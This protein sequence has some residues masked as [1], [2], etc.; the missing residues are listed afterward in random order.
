MSNGHGEDLSGAHLG[1]ALVRLG[2]HAV[3]F[4]LVGH[5]EAYKQLGIPTQPVTTHSF[6]THGMGYQSLGGVLQE[7][8]NGQ[9]IDGLRRSIT[10]AQIARHHD[11]VVAVGDVVPVVVAHL[12]RRTAFCYLM[13]YSS[14]YEG[15]L[16]LPW[17][18][19]QSLRSER[20]LHVFSRD[21]LTTADLSTRLGRRV[22]FLG[23]PFLDAVG[24][25]ATPLPSL[26]HPR[27]GLLPGSRLPEALNNLALMLAML[28]QLPQHPDRGP[29]G[30][31]AALVK[32]IKLDHLAAVAAQQGWRLQRHR[33]RCPGAAALELVHGD[34]GVELYWG[35][36]ADVLHGSQLLVAMAG[37]ATELAVGLEKPILQMPGTGP[38]FT[39]QFAEAQR[40]LLGPAVCCGAGPPGSVAN[41]RDTAR[42]LMVLLRD[43]D[44]PTICLRTAH[45]RI[46]RYGGS[47][48][49]AQTIL[50]SLN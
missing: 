3:G 10:A 14:Y 32:D 43:G 44:V 12:S 5:G 19:A 28:L 2:G 9:T 7:L 17:P 23:N 41:A 35:R 25:S 48:A 6:P 49:M 45:E 20:F 50:G 18:C 39:P 8:R 13:A 22:E 40:R 24:V 47:Q 21:R 4:P 34:L 46:G 15:R 33:P 1:Q 37:T 27:V 38:Q 16:T 42:L 26:S 31:A 29:L 36:F 30:L 11:A